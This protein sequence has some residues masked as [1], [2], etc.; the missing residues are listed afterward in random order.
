MW[1]H[2]SQLTFLFT[3]TLRSSQGST[4]RTRRWTRRINLWGADQRIGRKIRRQEIRPVPIPTQFDKT[5]NFLSVCMTH[6]PD[7]YQRLWPNNCDNVLK[8]LSS[9]KINSKWQKSSKNLSSLLNIPNYW[10]IVTDTGLE[11]KG[12]I[13]VSSGTLKMEE[14][15]NSVHQTSK[16]HRSPKILGGKYLKMK[17][18]SWW[19]SHISFNSRKAPLQSRL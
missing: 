7:E 17:I 13:F 2:Y 5:Q 16:F 1:S 6:L 18:I 19:F 3:L 14:V 12:K 8:T 15:F 11:R 4:Y 9:P 10:K